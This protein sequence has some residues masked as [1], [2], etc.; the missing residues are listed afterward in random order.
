MSGWIAL[1]RT[2]TFMVFLLSPFHG[3][4]END[5]SLTCG[6][7]MSPVVLLRGRPAV[8]HT[9]RSRARPLFDRHLSIFHTMSIRAE[10]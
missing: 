10:P 8:F 1:P 2:G 7:E 6:V 3:T 4:W 5:G 9:Y